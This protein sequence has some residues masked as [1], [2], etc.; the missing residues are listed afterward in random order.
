VTS[1][2]DYKVTSNKSNTVQDRAAVVDQ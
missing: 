2:P 1:N